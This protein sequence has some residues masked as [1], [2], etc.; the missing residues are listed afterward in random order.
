MIAKG[1]FTHLEFALIKRIAIKYE[2]SEYPI[3]IPAITIL[4]EA[5]T[6]VKDKII[7]ITITKPNKQNFSYFVSLIVTPSR[8]IIQTLKNSRAIL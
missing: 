2:P 5:F 7:Y 1:G 3:S 8:F 4:F 6:F